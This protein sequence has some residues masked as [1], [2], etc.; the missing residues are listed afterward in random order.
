MCVCVWKGENLDG[1]LDRKLNYIFRSTWPGQARN[2]ALK[3][4]PCPF[5]SLHQNH[6]HHTSKQA[7]RQNTDLHFALLSSSSPLNRFNIQIITILLTF[8]NRQSH[9][10]IKGSE[11]TKPKHRSS[12][13][14]K[15]TNETRKG[16]ESHIEPQPDSGQN[17]QHSI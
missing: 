14:C 10:L 11:A 15:Q 8:R 5:V 2:D 17:S 3:R 6:H 1:N 16:N 9:I 4:A 12:I 13:A 7:K